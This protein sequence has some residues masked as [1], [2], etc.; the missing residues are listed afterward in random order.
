[1]KLTKD[2]KLYVLPDGTFITLADIWRTER[3]QILQDQKL[4]ELVE[5]KSKKR[6]NGCDGSERD[7]PHCDE[8]NVCRQLL[9]DI[10]N[11]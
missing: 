10:R 7:C 8:I 9:E 6:S 2:S 3:E 4:R 11:E 5:K 1:M